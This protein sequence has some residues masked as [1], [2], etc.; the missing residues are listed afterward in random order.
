MISQVLLILSCL[1]KKKILI[2]G[3][4]QSFIAVNPFLVLI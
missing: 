2:I 3:T 1:V 4:N